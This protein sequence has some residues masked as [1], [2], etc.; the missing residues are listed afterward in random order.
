M[1]KNMHP[2]QAIPMSLYCAQSIN[3]QLIVFAFVK[4][5]FWYI[6]CSIK[7]PSNRKSWYYIKVEFIVHFLLA[8]FSIISSILL[9]NIIKLHNIAERYLSY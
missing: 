2:Q 1:A 9:Q 8:L 6:I 3:Q 4:K 7:C 5:L